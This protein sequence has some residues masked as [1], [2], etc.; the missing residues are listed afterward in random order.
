M[1]FIRPSIPPLDFQKFIRIGMQRLPSGVRRFVVTER[2]CHNNGVCDVTTMMTMMVK[3]TEMVMMMMAVKLRRIDRGS[4]PDGVFP[5]H[6]F[7]IS[8][9]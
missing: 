7:T 2:V 4:S 8:P 5:L 9:H 1:S 6:A 3:I